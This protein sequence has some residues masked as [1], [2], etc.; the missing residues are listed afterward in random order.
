MRKLFKILLYFLTFLLIL[1]ICTISLVDLTPPSEKAY[2]SVMMNRLDSLNDSLQIRSSE[3]AKVGTAKISITPDSTMALA[4]YGARKPK[5][6]ESV[7]DSVFVRTIVIKTSSKKVAILSADLLIIHP[8]ITKALYQKLPSIKWDKNIG[9]PLIAKPDVGERGVWVKKL[10]DKNELKQYTETCPVDFLLQELVSFPV[11]LGVFYVK[12]PEEKGRV[13]SIVRK[14]FLEVVGDG[15]SSIEEI[16]KNN[17]RAVLT[18][19][20]SSDFLKKE[21]QSIPS[22]GETRLVEPIG[23]HCLGTKFLNDENEI[24][25][26]LDAAINKIAE[27]IPDFYFGRFDIKCQ[28]LGD[29]RKL[30]NFSILELNGAGSEPGHIYQPGYSI[31]RAYKDIF[32]HLRV[33]A[34]ISILN[35]KRGIPYWSFK[36]GYEKWKHHKKHNRL[37]CN[38]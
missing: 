10:N 2:Y 31:F 37:L 21:G 34:D 20:F 30:K 23:N 33:L 16:L 29:L 32:W 3:K 17:P 25:E 26:E 7:L 22:K 13:T 38:S 28:S 36:R 18:A 15:K 27:E 14:E 11:E 1:S 19:D 5:D 24:D 4:G 9:Y 35:H 8:D 6:F 12:F